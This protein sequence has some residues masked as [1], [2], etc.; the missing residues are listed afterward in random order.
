[1]MEYLNFNLLLSTSREGYQAR[2]LNSP[3]GGASTSFNLPVA[4]QERI[5]FTKWLV[6][7]PREIK[8]S[9]EA[10]LSTEVNLEE[11][12]QELWTAV[13]KDGIK[14][15]FET[16]LALANSQNQGLRISLRIAEDAPELSALP[17]E[18]LYDPRKESFV[19][20]STKT[21]LVRYLEVDS[22][23]QSLQVDLPLRLLLV[24]SSPQD[25]PAL[26][27][28][29]EWQL[30]SEALKDLKHRGLVD[31]E[32]LDHVTLDS[33]QD[34]LQTFKPH[35]FHYIGHGYF[36]EEEQDG[37]LLFE[38]NDYKGEFVSSTKL[39]TAL[40]DHN[41][42]RLILLNA[43]N[44]ARTPT[45]VLDPFA[46][47]AQRLVKAGLPAVLAM[48]FKIS[49]QSAIKFSQEFYEAVALAYPI[50]AALAVARKSISYQNSEW[51]T[52]V[53]FMRTTDSQLFDIDLQSK[54]QLEEN[55][56]LLTSPISKPTK[57]LIP[58]HISQNQI[59]K[60]AAIATIVSALITSFFIVYPKS[61]EWY[62]NRF[63]PGALEILTDINHIGDDKKLHEEH[64]KDWVPITNFT[65][66]NCVVIPFEIETTAIAQ[67]ISMSYGIYGAQDRYE[68]KLNEKPLLISDNHLN[69]P[70]NHE[71][72]Y[73]HWHCVPQLKVRR[74]DL[75][76]G[77]NRLSVCGTANSTSKDP[78][79][80]L[81]D[82]QIK[83]INLIFNQPS[84]D[85][86]NC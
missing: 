73:N 39:T 15:C 1:M 7:Q 9:E 19:F 61:L 22:P 66:S 84:I 47:T 35:I 60:F 42:L 54:D 17:W 79:D 53:L 80:K 50:D 33:L 4:N 48:Q 28:E 63:N 41:T 78:I 34:T 40:K 68:L 76:K 24:T 81:D 82:F 14:R 29:E 3:A 2:V 11:L 55:G 71:Y 13:F 75:N 52:P 32:R 77:I 51:G 26:N 43:C 56:K 72:G 69:N 27:I 18:Y 38:D 37:G 5:Q 65:N 57:G 6:Q 21:H 20:L 31:Y 62:E 64:P 10:N 74:R 59:Q 25:H 46:G 45:T 49:D 12:G 67:K 85:G 16:S 36:D 44:G 83:N 8:L 70:E 58:V 23:V 30:L 86:N